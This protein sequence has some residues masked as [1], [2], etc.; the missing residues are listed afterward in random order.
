MRGRST[1]SCG[2]EMASGPGDGLDQGGADLVGELLELSLGELFEVT[3]G[4]DAREHIPRGRGRCCGRLWRH[5]AIA[6][7][8][9]ALP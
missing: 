3:W 6:G 1:K 8:H 4:I 2:A 5:L 7:C 9:S